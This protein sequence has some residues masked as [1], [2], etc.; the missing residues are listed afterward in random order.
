MNEKKTDTPDKAPSGKKRSK[1][2][3]GQNPKQSANRSRGTKNNGTAVRKKSGTAAASAGRQNNSR[4]RKQPP[5]EKVRIIPL[6]GLGEIGKNMTVIEY[7]NEIIIVDCGLSFPDDDMF[8]IDK[9]IPD[10]SYLKETDK[11]IR[12]LVITHGHEDHIGAVPYLLKELK[13]PVYGMAFPLGLIENKLKEYGL[14][15]DLRQVSAGQTFRMGRHFSIEAIRITH[16]IADSMCLAIK[17]PA[18]R[19]FHTGD[20]KIDYTPVDGDPIDFARLAQIG[21][22]GVLLMMADSTNVLRPGFTE[23]ERVVGRTLEGIFRDSKNRIIIATFSSNVHRIQKIIDL[24]I[25][26]KRK[27]AVSGRS[28][29]NVVELAQELGYIRIPQHMLVDLNKAKNIPDKELVVITTGSQGEPMSALARMASCEHKTIRIKKGDRV[30]LSSSPVPGNELT[31]AN[32]VNQLIQKGAEV[33]YSDIADIHV[34]GH[35]CQEE[36]KLMHSLIR[37]KYFMPVHGEYR[38]L[39]THA[40]LANT[41]GMAM[42]NIFIL[43]NGDCLNITDGRAKIEK[44]IADAEGIMVDGLGVGDVGNIVLRDRRLL[45]ESGLIILVAAI[46]RNSN[47]IAS[48]PD[49]ISRGFVYVRENEH[50]I[51]EACRKAEE[52]LEDCLRKNMK[53]WNGMKTVV[54]ENLRK[55]IYSKTQRS[56]VILPIFLEV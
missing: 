15:A 17:T 19:I 23:S 29:V 9:V 56:P 40:A 8:G 53:D 35:A 33:I 10:F 20:F 31:V 44:N 27:V 55:Y 24:A 42:D 45:S 6:G 37:P 34:S 38:H 2:K 7:G 25:Q 39:Q 11:K 1:P 28:M 52:I 32:V 51:D 47:T 36:L 22:E 30:I 5:A 49:I 21:S 54:R 4:K 50:L 13:M 43:S 3:N 26:C 46:D 41:L 18:G 14:K 12:G 16:S 48:G